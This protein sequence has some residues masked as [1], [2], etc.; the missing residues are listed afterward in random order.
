[1]GRRKSIWW[2][3]ESVPAFAYF[4][5][6]FIREGARRMRGWVREE[7]S[8]FAGRDEMCIVSILAICEAYEWNVRKCHVLSVTV[9][10][11]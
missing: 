3:E 11:G 6:N 2:P 1:M 9:M 5:N 4:Y 10:Y 8:A 7:D